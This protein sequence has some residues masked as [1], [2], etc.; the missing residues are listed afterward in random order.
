MKRILALF[1][2]VA[3][4]SIGT[5][6]AIASDVIVFPAKNGDVTFNHKG[7]MDRMECAACHEGT[8]GKIGLDRD[9]AHKLCRDCHQSKGAGPVKCGECHKK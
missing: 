8:P 2:T 5:L 1:L 9:S 4:I 7:H 6:A 3:F